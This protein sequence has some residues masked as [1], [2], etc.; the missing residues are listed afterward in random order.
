MRKSSLKFIVAAAMLLAVAVTIFTGA[1]AA[2]AAIDITKSCRFAPSSNAG[3]FTKAVDGNLRTK[4]MSARAGNR[5]IGITIP[6]SEK[7]GGIYFR[8]D[9]APAS[10]ELFAHESDGSRTSVLKGGTEGY[11]TQFVAIPQ[12]FAGCKEFTLALHAGSSADVGLAEIS[13]F[14]PGTPPYYAP[15]W[16]TFSGRVD[17]LTIVAH[18]D[19]ED[20]YMG[21]PP[22]TYADQGKKCE[23][24]FMTYG[25]KSTSARRFEAQESAWSLGNPF[26]PVMGNF[27]DVKTVTKE[28]AMK[29]WPLDKVVS[30]LVEQIRKYKPSVIVTHDVMGE[31][32]HGE[33][34]LTEYAATLAFQ[35]AADPARYPDSAKEFGTWKAAKLYVHL[36]R[37]DMLNPM[38]LTTPLSSFGGQTVLQVIKDAYSRQK[39][40]LPGRLLPVSGPYDM[41]KFGLFSSNV[42]PDE[43]H[44][45]MF[46][47]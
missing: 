42:G 15:Q 35:E 23:T 6:P 3:S 25:S 16:K 10:W 26:Y 29:H 4:W 36:Y 43:K 32:W 27:I 21:V 28:Q 34:R 37:K 45:S 40:Q 17:L 8:W 13:I 9:K 20:L 46:E 47:M 44:V 5:T 19:D 33:H 1:H 24:V 39:S 22:P 12:D 11:L 14:S 18:P 2:S 31:Y 38:S 7:A 30:F 41:R